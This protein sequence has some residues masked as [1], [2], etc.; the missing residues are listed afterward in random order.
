MS[1]PRADQRGRSR[2]ALPFVIAA[3]LGCGA[4]PEPLSVDTYSTRGIVRR[5]PSGGPAG[6]ELYIHHEAIAAFKDSRGEVV[7][8]ESMAMPFPVAEPAL[9]NGLQA[10]DRVEFDFEVSWEGSPPLRIIRLTE[11][12]ADTRLSFE[13]AAD[14]DAEQARP[15][16]GD[17]GGPPETV[18]EH[19]E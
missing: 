15:P 1:F 4:A 19:P 8:M 13:P 7:G 2:F 16:D 9:L 11:L 17:A 6:Q 10:G 3:V 12:P 5:M 18:H 14:A